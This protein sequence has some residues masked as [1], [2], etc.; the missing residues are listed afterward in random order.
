MYENL[1]RSSLAYNELKKDIENEN[2]AHA[3]LFSGSDTVFFEEL[4]K[5][6]LY[7]AVAYKLGKSSAEKVT[8]GTMTDIRYFPDTG[9]V[10]VADIEYIIQNAYI[11][12]MESDRK[13]YVIK[14]AQTMTIQ[15]QNKLLKILEEPPSVAAFIIIT[16]SINAILPTIVSR[17]RTVETRPFSLSE[18]KECDRLN[19]SN[20]KD[21]GLAASLSGGNL[22]ILENLLSDGEY[23]L[24]FEKTLE[25]LKNM[26]HSSMA[27]KYL[28]F[29]NESKNY[30]DWILTCLEIIFTDILKIRC[31][32]KCR[33]P[34]K[35]EADLAMLSEAFRPEA[36][37]EL[38]TE[39][40]ALRERK[41]FYSNY[42]SMVDELLLKILE[43]KSKWQRL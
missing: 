31:G 4:C 41:K 19:E 25:M 34:S 40:A 16:A 20:C 43:V 8:N 14:N 38:M 11:T 5:C 9:S 42:N 27:V 12:P 7:E 26:T 21:K 22:T 10:T 2:V 24:V 30:F 28:P 17:C 13:F 3:Y 32:V 23:I 37:S 1:I 29:F 39:T 15:A 6:F 35:N 18:I 33:L 36:I